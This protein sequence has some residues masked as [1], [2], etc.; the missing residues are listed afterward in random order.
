M[1]LTILSLNYDL[2]KAIL[3]WVPAILTMNI[4]RQDGCPG[5]CY[6]LLT[7]CNPPPSLHLP[8]IPNHRPTDRPPDRGTGKKE[9]RSEMKWQNWMQH[10]KIRS[11]SQQRCEISLR[12]DAAC[13]WTMLSINSVGAGYMCT[14]LL[15]FSS[16][17]GP[18]EP[19]WIGR[20]QF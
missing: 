9:E 11:S 15:F 19:S 4:C 2:K 13:C 7:P 17:H 5:E 3:P 12:L 16:F 18:Y 20:D 1:H 10:Q 6:S 8:E 14:I